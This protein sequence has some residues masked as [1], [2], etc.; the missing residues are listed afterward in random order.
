M[1]QE[2]LI[3]FQKVMAHAFVL[4]FLLLYL[5][6]TC[7]ISKLGFYDKWAMPALL[8]TGLVLYCIPEV[9]LLYGRCFAISCGFWVT[10]YLLARGVGWFIG[11]RKHE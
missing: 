1:D 5:L 9:S 2:T 6:E 7:V 4:S 3:H 10:L 11:L 8:M